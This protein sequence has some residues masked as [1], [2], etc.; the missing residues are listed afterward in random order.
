MKSK[1]TF[2]IISAFPE[3][4][5]S[6]LG[7]SIIGRAIKNKI[8]KVEKHDLK[9]W[10]E[11]KYNKI[12]DKPYGGGPGMVLK[13]EPIFK[14]I[15]K[16]KS[17]KNLSGSG[18]K[19]RTILFST[20]GNKFSQREAQ[21]LLKYGNIIFICGRY[22]GVDERVARHMADEEISVGDFVLSG[23]EI[24]AL[25]VIDSIARLIPG[26]LGKEES[27][28]EN[29]GSFPSYTRPEIF[30]PDRKNKRKKWVVPKIL[31]S[32]DHKKIKEWRKERP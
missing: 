14:A 13:V 30:Y 4:L 21:R 2:H 26:V 18:Q 32:G 6:Y 10:G 8:I 22:E 15:S 28:E 11:G 31:L 29:K 5:D 19:T 27:L 3:M 9:K 16:I 23:G 24:P 20:R 17:K 7:A 12:D 25:I 1:I